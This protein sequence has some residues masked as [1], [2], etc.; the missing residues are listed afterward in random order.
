MRKKS[1]TSFAVS[2][3]VLVDKYLLIYK[4]GEAPI[5]QMY[6][7]TRYGYHVIKNVPSL[8][9]LPY[10]LRY[11]VPLARFAYSRSA[12][13]ESYHHPFIERH[14][15]HD[16]IYKELLMYC[17][18]LNSSHKENAARYGIC[19]LVMRD[20]IRCK[21]VVGNIRNNPKHTTRKYQRMSRH[22]CYS[23][24]NYLRLLHT[25]FGILGQ[26]ILTK[27]KTLF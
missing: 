19:T 20:I 2:H 21:A 4:S 5:I 15:Q 23:N 13:K 7:K 17:S 3:F 9:R 14:Y 8:N 12:I 10:F 11:R 27:G 24:N 26:L 25:K 18:L 6:P 22:C 1:L 16:Y